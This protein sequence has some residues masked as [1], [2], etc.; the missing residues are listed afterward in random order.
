MLY[1]SKGL[2]KKHRLN[3][4]AIVPDNIPVVIGLKNFHFRNWSKNPKFILQYKRSEKILLITNE[5]TGI[6]REENTNSSQLPTCCIY[7]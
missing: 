1:G 3:T 6:S 2:L 5:I 4:T 7:H